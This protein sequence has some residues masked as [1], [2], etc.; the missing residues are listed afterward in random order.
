MEVEN[1]MRSKTGQMFSY[2]WNNKKSSTNTQTH[3]HKTH[4]IL[5]KNPWHIWYFS[6]ATHKIYSKTM[7]QPLITL[8]TTL[9]TVLLCVCLFYLFFLFYVC[10]FF[11]KVI[12]FVLE[13]ARM[14]WFIVK[15]FC[16]KIIILDARSMMFM[17][18]MGLLRLN[19]LFVYAWN[20]Y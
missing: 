3:T 20:A 9:K 5:E 4:A 17:F 14:K 8:K 7:G 12:S 19:F 10:F 2:L 1:E 13:S 6:R 16:N 15:L 18:F 11:C